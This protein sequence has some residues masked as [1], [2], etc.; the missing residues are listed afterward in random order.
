MFKDYYIL[1][2]LYFEYWYVGDWVFWIV[3]CCW[4][5]G[6]VGVD[7][8]YGVGVVEIVVDFIYF[9]YD[10][11]RYFGFCQQDVYMFWEVFGYWMNIKVYFDILC[12]QFFGNFCYWILCLSYCYIVVWGDDY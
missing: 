8:Q 1:C 3:L 10:V 2:F 6:I 5:D 12:L 4:V 9:Q 11:V 7:Y